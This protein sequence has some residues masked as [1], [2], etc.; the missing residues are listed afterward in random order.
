MQ[1]Y[2]VLY[3]EPKADY[4]ALT[5][6]DSKEQS[7]CLFD[8]YND[9]KTGYGGKACQFEMETD[10]ELMS[11]TNF[12]DCLY[13]FHYDFKTNKTVR[14]FQFGTDQSLMLKGYDARR[15]FSFVRWKDMHIATFHMGEGEV[16]T[17]YEHL[18]GI[19]KRIA[20]NIF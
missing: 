17:R 3:E 7:D 4:Y 1:L 15:L 19:V 5:C 8:I 14:C 10:D 11:F 12:D 9:K 13:L 16:L 2:F 18:L 20:P 6:Y